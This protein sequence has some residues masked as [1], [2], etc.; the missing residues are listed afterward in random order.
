MPKVLYLDTNILI[1]LLERHE[2]FS[3]IVAKK[4]DDF[5]SNGNG[6]L[7]T[8]VIT[9]TEFLAATASSSLETLQRV[10]RLKFIELDEVLAEQAG[11]IKRQ[12]HLQI[13]DA[14]HLATAMQAEAE[15]FFTNDKRL[16]RIASKHLGIQSL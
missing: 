11:L 2:R 9:V 12:N 13:G 8:S 5:T 16:A 10:P 4:L 1:Y 7:V 14:I 6:T 3:D 15:S